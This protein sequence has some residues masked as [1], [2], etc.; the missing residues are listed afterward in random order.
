MRPPAVPRTETKPEPLPTF[1][2]LAPCE[3]CGQKSWAVPWVPQPVC[4]RCGAELVVVE[5]YIPT[6]PQG[7]Q[8]GKDDAPH[9]NQA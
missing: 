4:L 3:R 6:N 1:W 9:P 2:Q 8:F 7:S 5:V